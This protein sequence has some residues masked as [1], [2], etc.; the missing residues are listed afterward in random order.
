MLAQYVQERWLEAHPNGKLIHR[1]LARQAIP[2]IQNKTIEGFY[3][4]TDQMSAQHQR[5]TALSDELIEELKASD[6]ILISS[7]LYNL[8][9]P[10]NL[11][12]YFDQVV[13]IGQTFASSKEGYYGILENKTAYLMTVK[14]GVYQG[15]SMA[16]YD[17]QEPYL[18]TILNFIGIRTAASFSLEGTSNP[19]TLEE[20]KLELQKHIDQY[21]K[22]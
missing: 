14:G 19:L 10:S 4:P 9:I 3:L 20:K 2:H 5:A 7:P 15:T 13:R 18:R 6:D 17:F 12:A 1:D 22:N 8:N 16:Q 11:K 21:F